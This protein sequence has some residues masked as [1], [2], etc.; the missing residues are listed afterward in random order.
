[1]RPV[2][3]GE[4]YYTSRPRSASR[5]RR[6]TTT[7]RGRKL[8]FIT[9][10]GV[11]SADGVDSGSRL[12]IETVEL[13]QQGDVLDLGCGYGVLGI[14]CAVV[15]PGLRVVM[16]DIN[17][18]ALE[19]AR[20]NARLNGAANIEILESDGFAALAGRRFDLIL[21]NPPFRQGKELVSSWL[22]ESRDHLKPGGRLAMVVRTQQGA[23][24][25]RRRLEEWY[26]H[27]QELEKKGG[28]RVYQVSVGG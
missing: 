3:N 26:G 28:Y 18:R 25:W 14:T 21:T 6:W 17:Q 16:V 15:E 9:D 1:M 12:L 8:V 20:Q 11:F 2:G 23:R 7:L 24:S 13:P 27:C 10:A 5:P 22:R 4:H 19:L